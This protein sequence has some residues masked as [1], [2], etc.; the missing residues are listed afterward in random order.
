VKSKL[1]EP[2]SA[3]S[4][5]QPGKELAIIL[6]LSSVWRE[7]CQF[8]LEGH[9]QNKSGRTLVSIKQMQQ[10]LQTTWKPSYSSMARRYFV[11]KM[12]EKALWLSSLSNETI[13]C[14]N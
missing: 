5:G 14:K 3:G 13:V 7:T 2:P 12:I 6:F 11:E 8:V 1:A 10:L 4:A 9:N